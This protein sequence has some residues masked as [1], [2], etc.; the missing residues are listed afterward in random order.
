MG[1]VGEAFAR[2]AGSAR[3]DELV[4]ARGDGGGWEGGEG[5]CCGTGPQFC[6]ARDGFFH[7]SFFLLSNWPRRE[8]LVALCH[9]AKTKGI[10]KYIACSSRRV[11]LP[12][13]AAWVAALWH[14]SQFWTARDGIPL[15]FLYVFQ[16]AK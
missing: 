1:P 15:E 4:P 12:Q 6:S 8:F 9:L 2:H 3:G 5:G 7:Y 13:A 14:R 11:A 10:D 16:L